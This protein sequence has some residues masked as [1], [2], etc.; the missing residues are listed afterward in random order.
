MNEKKDKRK[1]PRVNT[2][3][4]VRY[5]KLGDAEGT[6]RS[7]SITRNLCE[8]GICF[9]ASGFI[10]RACRLIMELDIPMVTKPVKAISKV[11]WIRKA[12]SGDGDDYEVGGHF[13]EIS[14]KDRE[15]VSE[16]V[17]SLILYNDSGAEQK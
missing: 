9:K 4:P 6:L 12:Q 17:S 5:R 13:L 11:A 1:Y 14:R 8:G 3:I 2:Y 10:S 15:L 7:S 16:Y